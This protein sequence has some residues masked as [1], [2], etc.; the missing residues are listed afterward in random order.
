MVAVRS[1]RCS[2]LNTCRNLSA[3]ASSCAH[4]CHQ[5]SRRYSPKRWPCRRSRPNQPGLISWR[6]HCA[7]LLRL[8]QL[9]SGDASG[10]TGTSLSRRYFGSARQ[11]IEDKEKMLEAGGAYEQ[12]SMHVT[13]RAHVSFGHKTEAFRIHRWAAFTVPLPLDRLNR[14][15]RANFSVQPM[16]HAKWIV[17]GTDSDG[18]SRVAIFR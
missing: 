6:E 3:C 9:E 16:L 14:H 15:R 18:T 17:L 12:F 10:R 2:R 13:C 11:R 7:L 5:N 8:R 4:S 1:C